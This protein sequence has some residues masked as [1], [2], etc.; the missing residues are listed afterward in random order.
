MDEHSI[1]IGFPPPHPGAYVRDAKQELGM[2]VKELA[3]HLGVERAALSDLINEKKRVSVP[4]AV[5]LGQ[6]FR[7]GARFWMALQMQHDV[8]HAERKTNIK[9]QP[10][11]WN[12]GDVA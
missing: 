5:R 9:V 12:D 10:I 11:A 3:D 2:T 1:R 4:M 8:W 7:N 6:A